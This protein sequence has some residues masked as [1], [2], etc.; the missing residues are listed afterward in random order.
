MS[1]ARVAPHLFRVFRLAAMCDHVWDTSA[2]KFYSVFW[3][4]TLIWSRNHRPMD[5]YHR[6]L[7]R[8][9]PEEVRILLA[10]CAGVSIE[11]S[12]GVNSLCQ[13]ACYSVEDASANF[14][15]SRTETSCQPGEQCSQVAAECLS[16]FFS[17]K[18]FLARRLLLLPRKICQR[19]F[20]VANE[21]RSS[22][23]PVT[24]LQSLGIPFRWSP[25]LL[26]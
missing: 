15:R 21:Q 17:L 2:S 9:P 4:K 16:S 8:K 5:H 10:D 7:F 25:M 12:F 14:C 19:F 22:N 11:S 18:Q 20:A 24:F 23:T 6:T 1:L 3:V 13:R 26:A